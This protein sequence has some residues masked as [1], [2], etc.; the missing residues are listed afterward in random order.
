MMRHILGEERFA[1]KHLVVDVRDA[2]V[3]TCHDAD[4][5]AN[6]FP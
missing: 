2:L 3:T 1:C 4:M 5:L 6:H